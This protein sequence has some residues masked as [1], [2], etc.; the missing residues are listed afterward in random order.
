MIPAF[1][2][3]PPPG[4]C[5]VALTLLFLEACGGPPPGEG[6]TA[7]TTAGQLLRRGNGGEPQTLD[8]L[9]A[10]DEHGHN[11]LVDL[12]EG[13]TA[14]SAD[15]TLVPGAASRWDV[16]SDGLRYTF[17]LR[18]DAAWSNGDP[19]VAEEFIAT[20]QR[21]VSPDS[22]SP[23]AGLFEAIENFAGV[24][25]GSLPP[26]ALGVRAIDPGTLQIT[27]RYPVP[28]FPSLIAMPVASPD[29]RGSRGDPL[30]YR[31]PDHFVGN[32]AFVL[33]QWSVG[34]KIRL[35]R[36]PRYRD[37]GDI[38][39]D[40][41]EFLPISD[42]GTELGVYRAGEL[43][44][45][46]TIPP[47][48]MGMLRADRRSEIHIAPSLGLY[49]LAFDLS[50][51]PF[52]NPLLR[53]ALTAAID[54]RMLTEI[55]G[56]GEVAAFGVVPPGTANHVSQQYSWSTLDDA[57]R[58]EYARELLDRAG[59]GPDRPVSFSLTY[60]VGDIHETVALAVTAMWRDALGV[61]VELVKKEWKLFLATRDMRDD[62]DVMRFAWVGD[63]NDATTFLEL[64]RSG[65]PQN[66]P[67]HSNTAYDARLDAAAASMS[68]RDRARALSEAETMLLTDYPIAPLYFL[69]SKHLV[70]DKVSG[71]E[72]NILDRHP[73]RFMRIDVTPAP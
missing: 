31:D 13:L 30:R 20:F 69:V 21:L 7:S 28:Y 43:H 2:R 71:F 73:T 58:I 64:F 65:S 33:D 10:D 72:T 5:I 45:T 50:E 57:A 40:V 22:I 37:A 66:L 60:D 11:I 14:V 46:Q 9:L 4:L 24:S 55:L 18:P 29:H 38:L 32:G 27:L 42:P 23:Y 41:V 6:A 59:Y 1:V 67:G 19:V 51:E 63:Y 8:P 15:G 36:N 47:E 54:R 25:D 49:Y 39:I 3:R 26:E 44:I 35:R 70:S 61:E 16:S 34:E 56:R 53:A 52:D 12:Y 68:S 17:H 48:A 62:W